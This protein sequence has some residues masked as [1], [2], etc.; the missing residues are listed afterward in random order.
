MTMAPRHLWLVLLLAPAAHAIE[1]DAAALQL[2]DLPDAPAAAV[3]TRDWRAHAEL[4]AGIARPRDGAQAPDSA[5]LS[6]DAVLDTTLAPGWRL[7]LSDRLDGWAWQGRADR[8]INT[9]REAYVGWQPDASTV[10]DL[11][12]VNVRYGAGLGYN[13][14]D[15]F[16]AGALRSVTSAA[17]QALR[18]NRQGSVMLRGQ[19]LW[20][21]GALTALWSPELADSPSDDGFDLDLGATNP[22]DRWLLVASQRVNDWFDPQWLLYGEPGSV[23]AGVNWSVLLSDA[24]VGY[25]EWAGGKQPSLLARSR[26]EDDSAFRAAYTVGATWTTSFK[27]SVSAEYQRDNSAVDADEWKALQN[28]VRLGTQRGSADDY[29]RYRQLAGTRQ[30]LTTREGLML[31]A[32]W[33]DAGVAG[34]DLAGY[35]RRDLVDASW[36]SWL[37]ARWRGRWADLTAQWLYNHGTALSNYGAAPATQRWQLALTHYF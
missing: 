18:E 20:Q 24:L 9:L 36:Q 27:L 10:V 22:A 34:L 2:A 32:S 23:Q 17:P 1:P 15:F 31:Y 26:G 19:R 28:D 12:R 5:R 29:A 16:K 11:G 35:W 4:A 25:V 37:Q 33:Q 8:A 7:V 13:P 14:T 6:L 21:G 3:P 30:A